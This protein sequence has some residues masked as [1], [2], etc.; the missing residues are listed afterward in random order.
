MLLEHINNLPNI[1]FITLAGELTSTSSCFILNIHKGGYVLQ[2]F[3]KVVNSLKLIFF[4]NLG[5]FLMGIFCIMK[6]PIFGENTNPRMYYDSLCQKKCTTNV[7]LLVFSGGAPERQSPN[8]EHVNYFY[9]SSEYA[10][11]VFIPKFLVL[12]ETAQKE[13]MYVSQGKL[14]F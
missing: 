12:F 8:R 11:F 1:R 3:I 2:L 5:M 14:H 4:L 7:F 13:S 6:N 10:Q 9:G